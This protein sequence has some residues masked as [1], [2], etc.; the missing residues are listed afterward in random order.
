M[1]AS[2]IER[3]QNGRMTL[4]T[5]GDKDDDDVAKKKK[6]ICVCVYVVGHLTVC[7]HVIDVIVIRS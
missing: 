1:S 7:K 2:D 6:K 4:L 3:N 5:V